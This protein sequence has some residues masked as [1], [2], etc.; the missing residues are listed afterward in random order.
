MALGKK[1]M[2]KRKERNLT[3]EAL[4]KEL[5]VTS[6]YISQIEKAQRNPSYG[7]LIKLAHVLDITVDYLLAS[8]DS[9]SK[10]PSLRFIDNALRFFNSK[11]RSRV[12]D[13]IHQISGTKRYKQF[14]I[15]NSVEEYSSFIVSHLK[16][17]KIPVDPFEIADQLGIDVILSKKELK[18]EA[19]LFKSTE[20]PTI[21]LD[22]S[23]GSSAR[24]RFTVA[25][26]IGHLVI[27]WHLRP[28]FEREKERRSLD[29]EDQLEIEARKFA[30]ELLIPS[31]LVWRDFEELD[32]DLETFEN[33]A[34]GKYGCS[35]LAIAHKYIEKYA[36]TA[37]LITSRE[38]KPT[39]VYSSGLPYTLLEKPRE[40]SLVLTFISKPP[41]EKEYRKGF[42]EPN[43]WVLNPPRNLKVHEETLLDPK[44]GVAVSLLRFST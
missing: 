9:L 5:G 33:I 6:A 10:E 22:S 18:H 43:C 37:V 8:E 35:M 1:L 16:Y 20:R 40:G 12:I 2:K 28:V 4:A 24:Q 42:V 7:L 41:S 23:I 21:I 31:R 25:T 17:N 26:M 13:Y 19:M 36:K 30:G 38:G 32:P 29:L 44:E 15:L 27:P 34:Y 14:P 39:R 3:Q 11:Q